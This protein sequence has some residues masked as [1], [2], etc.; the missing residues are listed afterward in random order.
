M[1]KISHGFSLLEVLVAF[2]LVTGTSIA[3]FKQHFYLKSI[4][5]KFIQQNHLLE[6][7]DNQNEYQLFQLRDLACW[8]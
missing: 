8:N 3:L 6:I 7:A 4:Q 1:M 5:L 2:V